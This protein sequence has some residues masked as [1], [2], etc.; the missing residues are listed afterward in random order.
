MSVCLSNFW[1]LKLF[2]EKTCYLHFFLSS[3]DEVIFWK[4]KVVLSKYFQ[5]LID[6]HQKHEFNVKFRK[7]T[8]SC[9]SHRVLTL[10][11]LAPCIKSV[12]K[13]FRSILVEHFVECKHLILDKLL[14]TFHE[15]LTQYEFKNWAV[16]LCMGVDIEQFLGRF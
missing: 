8:H 4:K 2:L 1:C 6:Y 9:I 3:A 12:H 16:Y 5:D 10:L 13:K 11:H 14:D 15:N 7:V